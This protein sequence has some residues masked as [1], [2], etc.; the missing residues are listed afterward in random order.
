MKIKQIKAQLMRMKQRFSHRSSSFTHCLS[1]SPRLSLLSGVRAS[2]QS[3]GQKRRDKPRARLGGGWRLSQHEWLFSSTVYETG[4][5]ASIPKWK[6]R[7]PNHGYG[8]AAWV[9]T[10]SGAAE[11]PAAPLR[12]HPFSRTTRPKIPLREPRK[13]ESYCAK[14][15]VNYSI[16]KTRIH[17]WEERRA[18]LSK[19]SIKFD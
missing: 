10:S 9:K 1:G 16:K 5:S 3:S 11:T 4:K 7:S 6:P 18:R 15:F 19:K 14:I 12:T 8:K 13:R 2:K 17:F